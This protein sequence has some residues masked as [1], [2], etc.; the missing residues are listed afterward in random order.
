MY[1]FAGGQAPPKTGGVTIEEV[2]DEDD[3]PSKKKKKKKPKKKKKATTETAEEPGS[4]E[5]TPAPVTPVIAS[6]PAPVQATP[7]SPAKA[8][9]KPAP[10]PKKPAGPS[11]IAATVPGFT[12]TT[13]LTSESAAQSARSYLQ[14]QGLDEKKSKTKTRSDQPSLFSSVKARFGF[15]KPKAEYD[16]KASVR[17]SWFQGLPKKTKTLLHQLLRTAEDE[18]RGQRGMKWEAFV[19]VQS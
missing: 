9:K 8:A 6:P 3:G 16:E 18:T 19:K 1:L 5:P 13:S 7:P 11:G 14:S 4:P 10:S 17:R 12:S 2:D 15:G